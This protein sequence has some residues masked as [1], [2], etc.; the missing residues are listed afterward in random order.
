MPQVHGAVKDTIEY[1][2]NVIET[3]INSATDNPLIFANTNEHIEGG[4]FHGEPV[5]LGQWISLKLH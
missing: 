5:A 1:V 4:N 3:E 2:S